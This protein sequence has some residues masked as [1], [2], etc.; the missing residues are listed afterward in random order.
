MFSCFHTSSCEAYSFTTDGYGIFNVSTHLG[1]CRPHEVGS[2]TN[3][4]AQEFTPKYEIYARYTNRHWRWF[5]NRPFSHSEVSF[6]GN[7]GRFRRESQLQ[8]VHT[9]WPAKSPPPPTLVEMLQNCQQMII[10]II[11]IIDN[12]TII[13]IIIIVVVVVVDIYLYFCRMF[14]S[15]NF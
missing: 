9:T 6:T 2:D 5:Q 15:E 8:Q 4:S 11:I 12:N 13:T 10:F 3:K 14:P 1:A 7:S